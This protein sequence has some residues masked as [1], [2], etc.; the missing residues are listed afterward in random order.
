MPPTFE[1]RSVLLS[2]AI[3]LLSPRTGGVV[4]DCTLG[5][6]GHAEAVLNASAPDGRL[7]GFDRD[8]AAIAAASARLAPFGDRF[9]AVHGTFGDIG[10]HLARLGVGRVA[11]V[12]ADLGVSSPQ[13]DQAERGF[14]FG[15]NGPLDMRM[16]NTSGRS[17][18]ELVNTL[19]EVELADIIFR[20][21]EER[22]SRR[23]ARAIVAGRPFESTAQLADVVARAV[24]RSKDIH[25]ATRTFQAIRI[26]VN[27]E[28][29]ELERLMS[30]LPSLLLP[31]GRAAIISFHS[32]EDRIVKHR[33]REFSGVGGDRDAYGRPLDAPRATLLTNRAVRASDDNPRARSARLRAI[34]WL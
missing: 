12:L 1:H 31:G 6:G 30:A 13:L 17:A 7:I 21:G 19:A 33:F 26:A 23:V 14:S 10:A 24:G 3:A 34:Q 22:L 4:V 18:A 29:G 5:G 25:P 16:D 15:K 27:D 28:L 8:L 9:T 32:L 2:E 20:F 11:G